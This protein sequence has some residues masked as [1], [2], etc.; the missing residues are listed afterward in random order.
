MLFHCD[1]LLNLSPHSLQLLLVATLLSVVGA[2]CGDADLA[3][4]SASVDSAEAGDVGGEVGPDAGSPDVIDDQQVA[5]QQDAGEADVQDVFS[6]SGPDQSEADVVEHDSVAEDARLDETTADAQADGSAD[7][8]ADVADQSEDVEAETISD[9]TEDGDSAE[10]DLVLDAEIA[11]DVGVDDVTDADSGADVAFEVDGIV[12]IPDRDR[13]GVDDRIDN[14]VGVSNRSQSDLDNDGHGDACDN[15]EAT[16]NP[17][18]RDYNDGGP[19]DACDR[20]I[21]TPCDTASDPYPVDRAASN[22]RS[23]L[24]LPGDVDMYYYRNYALSPGRAGRRAYIQRAV[25][26]QHGAGRTGYSYFNS[27][28][29]AAQ[30]AGADRNT[31]IIAPHFQ[32]DDDLTDC[33]DD[34]ECLAEVPD[35]RAYWGSGGWKTGYDSHDAT[36]TSSFAVTDFIIMEHLANREW[37]PNLEEVI[38][39]GHSAGGQFVQRYA[40]GTEVDRWRS[41]SHLDFRFIVANPSSYV[42]LDER[43]WD[44]RTKN[45]VCTLNGERYVFSTPEAADCGNYNEYRYG[46]E[47][48]DEDHY[49]AAVSLERWRTNYRG[50]EVTYLMGDEDV[51]QTAE[52]T[53]L[54]T[55]C[56]A[57]FQG[58]CRYDRGVIYQAYMDTFWTPHS[59]DFVRVRGVG[60]S[61]GGM[62][63]STEG[64][65]SVFEVPKGP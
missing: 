2:A 39:T 59:H 47:D 16:Y 41:T 12:I 4:G 57:Q 51:S 34:G 18:Q 44:G 53:N 8:A 14:C 6:D 13:D 46:P 33:S 49:M 27:M 64:V 61:G 43:R 52:P 29:D 45:P 15:C 7:S 9:V 63:R 60:H 21:P 19:G 36:E 54:D 17:D 11:E 48:L 22:C 31:I 10:P 35:D 3:G 58:M 1:R 50:R 55:T 62:Y 37:Y 30:S 26:V 25:I 24:E 20:G 42:Y 65:L 23:T 56:R 5:N 28:M 38:I 40:V 32:T